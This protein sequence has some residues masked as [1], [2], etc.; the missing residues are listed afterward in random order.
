MH[1][2]SRLL[3]LSGDRRI[4]LEEC[5]DP[6]GMPVFFMHGWPASRLQGVGFGEAARALGVRILSPDRPGIGLSSFQPARRLLD[7][8]PLLAELADTLGLERFRIL[9]VSGGGP[10]AFAAAWAM[11]ERVAAIAVASGAPPLA[12]ENDWAGLMPI[13][14]WLLRAYR[15]Q[16]TLLRALFRTARPFATVRPPRWTH[17]WLLRFIPP[18]DRGALTATAVFEGSFECY[19]ESWRG[20]ALGVAT[21]AEIYAEPWG[22][23]LEEVRPPVRLW[24]GREDRSFPWTLAAALAARL[25]DCTTHFVEGEGHYSLPI[26]HGWKILRDLVECVPPRSP[27]AE[28]RPL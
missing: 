20:S 2:A 27:S 13:Y 26:R 24:H 1:L 12:A 23:P 14:R 17:P 18:A 21:D 15:R 3:T 9:A 16:P 22:F 6:D 10:Y 28:H 19:R 5:G 7:W 11:P 4:A 8:P 25:P